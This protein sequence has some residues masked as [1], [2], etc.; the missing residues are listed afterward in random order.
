MRWFGTGDL[1]AV[2]SG[3]QV[4]NKVVV[5]Y[6]HVSLVPRHGQLYFCLGGEGADGSL[7]WGSIELVSLWDG[8]RCEC[9]RDEA[10]G[11]LKTE[12]LPEYAKLQLSQ[13]RPPGALDL[14]NHRAEYSGC[15]FLPDGRYMDGVWLCTEKEVQDY[16]EMQRD[17]QHRVLICD[18]DDFT[19]LEIVEGKRVF[20]D[21]QILQKAAKESRQR[22]EMAMT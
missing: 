16:V 15:S 10:A 22:G 4:K 19:V 9:R 12:L 3:F 21:E 2:G 20:P 1:E 5:L 7:P 18:R 11:V 8:G 17:Y 13:I 6:D 14:Q